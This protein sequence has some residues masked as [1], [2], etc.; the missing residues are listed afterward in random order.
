MLSELFDRLDESI[1]AGADISTLRTQLSAIREEAEAIEAQLQE[2]QARIKE[3]EAGAQSQNRSG[4]HEEFEQGAKEL[5]QQFFNTRCRHSLEEIARTIGLTESMADYHADALV[6]AGMIQLVA[7]NRRG[8]M[9]MLT[10]EGR[11]Y[12]VRN[13]PA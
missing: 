1:G 3:L 8:T 9:Y 5:L 11:E 10:A 4:Q 13:K 2:A 7:A 12:I 6:Q